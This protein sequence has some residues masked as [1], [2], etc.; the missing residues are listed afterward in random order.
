MYVFFFLTWLYAYSKKCAWPLLTSPDRSALLQAALFSLGFGFLRFALL[1]MKFFYMQACSLVWGVFRSCERRS[2]SLLRGGFKPCFDLTT[3][4]SALNLEKNYDDVKR[5]RTV[6][7]RQD[8]NDGM[9]CRD[10]NNVCYVTPGKT[11]R[12]SIHTGPNMTQ[13]RSSAHKRVLPVLRRLSTASFLSLSSATQQT[14]S[15]RF[16]PPIIR[17]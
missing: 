4:I 1:D 12:S 14:Q 3:G 9:M 7:R 6:A 8:M 10:N 5:L 15:R 16:L 17:Q 2:Y 11:S 13:M